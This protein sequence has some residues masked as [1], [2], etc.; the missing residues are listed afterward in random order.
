MGFTFKMYLKTVTLCHLLEVYPGPS[1]I[2]SH[3]T[4]Y[5]SISMNL[6]Q[7]PQWFYENLGWIISPLCSKSDHLTL[8][9][10]ALGSVGP[11]PSGKLSLALSLALSSQEYC[12]LCPKHFI[13]VARIPQGW[14]MPFPSTIQC[15]PPYSA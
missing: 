13:S 9:Y 1:A 11:I 2:I 15:A 7:Q 14:M 8:T 4:Y 12:P 5:V 6:T 10:W 3:L